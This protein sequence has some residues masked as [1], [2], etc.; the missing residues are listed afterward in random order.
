MRR[1]LS[2]EGR[3][4]RFQQRYADWRWTR[5]EFVR[6]AVAWHDVEHRMVI[7]VLVKAVRTM[8][9]LWTR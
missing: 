8:E 1:H 3:V 9:R 7:P 2:I 5:P 4:V 6:L